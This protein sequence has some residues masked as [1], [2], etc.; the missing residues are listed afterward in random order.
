MIPAL[1]AGLAVVVAFVPKL[2]L[3]IVI[4]VVGL[5]VARLLS[6]AL[7]RLL[8]RVGFDRLVERGGIAR[9]LASSQL[10]PSDIVA[11]LVYYA[12]VL[13][14]LEFAFGV[15][16]P[17]PISTVLA[18]IIG[19]LPQVIV[20]I[21]IVIIAAAIAAA[22]KTLIQGTLGGLSYGKVLANAASIGVLFLGVIAALNQL[23][24]AFTVTTP[25]LITVLA[26]IG[27]VIVVGVGGGLIKPMQSRWESYL[28]RVEADLPKAKTSAEQAPPATQQLTAAARTARPRA[29][30]PAASSRARATAVPAPTPAPEAGAADPT[31]PSADAP[32]QVVPTQEAPSGAPTRDQSPTTPIEDLFRTGPVDAPSDDGTR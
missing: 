2:L 28:T 22:A 10:D 14:V 5:I 30:K 12:L 1:A 29:R 31:A 25:V 6:R 11:K 26:T 15:F 27:G 19:Y 20:A 13:F 24:I 3:A 32:T 18:T 17:N 7:S 8:T 21:I 16:G 9:A 23:G 4:L